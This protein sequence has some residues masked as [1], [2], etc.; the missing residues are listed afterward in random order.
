LATG[1]GVATVVT[2]MIVIS[3]MLTIV[4]R[5]PGVRPFPW[6]SMFVVAVASLALA[7]TIGALQMYIWWPIALL[8]GFPVYLGVLHLLRVDGHGGLR[9][10]LDESRGITHSVTT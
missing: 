5:I 9:Q 1:S 10:L 4:V 8:A 3:V 6:R 7:A 2:E